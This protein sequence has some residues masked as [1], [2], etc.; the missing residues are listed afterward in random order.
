MNQKTV[1][2]INKETFETSKV[3]VS[4]NLNEIKNQL[5]YFSQENNKT[6]I[7]YMKVESGMEN[8]HIY[9]LTISNPVELKTYTRE[10]NWVQSGQRFDIGRNTIATIEEITGTKFERTE[11]SL[12][13][14]VSRRYNPFDITLTASFVKVQ[15]R[16]VY[17]I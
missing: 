11:V 16:K 8:R 7:S 14:V 9:T 6:E 10:L 5:W 2:Q 13:K 1:E 15:K 4:K 12:S 17:A 3:K